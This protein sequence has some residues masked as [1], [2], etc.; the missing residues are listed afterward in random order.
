MIAKIDPGRAL[1]D[2]NIIFY[3]ADPAAGERREVALRL[4]ETLRSR[5]E[6]VVS[7]QVLNEFYNAATRA[8]KQLCLPHS[9]AVRIV[10]DLAQAAEVLPL[11]ASVTLRALDA[12][13]R[14]GFSFW[15]ALIWAAAKENG[16]AIVYTEDFQ[17]GRDVEGV[18]I[19]NPF[20]TTT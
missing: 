9:D 8:R 19:V 5:R 16:V 1:V 18:R 6:L 20:L 4:I 14:H 2:T 15:D 7:T 17:H 3:S 11:D 12:M 10:T 13:P